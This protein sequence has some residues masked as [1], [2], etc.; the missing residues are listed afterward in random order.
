MRTMAKLNLSFGWNAQALSECTALTELTV[1]QN[2]LSD[3]IA[4]M[5][6]MWLSE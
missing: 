3:A 5:I 2:E 1:K 6:D 4:S